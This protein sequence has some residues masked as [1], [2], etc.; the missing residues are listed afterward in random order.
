ME[1]DD[2]GLF[3]RRPYLGSGKIRE[4]RDSDCRTNTYPSRLNRPSSLHRE[5]RLPLVKAQELRGAIPRKDE[6]MFAIS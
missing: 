4:N 2:A 3:N 5:L 6:T 1:G